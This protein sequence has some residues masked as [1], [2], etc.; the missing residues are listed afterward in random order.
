MQKSETLKEQLLDSSRFV[1]IR[2]DSWIV[3]CVK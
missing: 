3:H 2:V 1:A